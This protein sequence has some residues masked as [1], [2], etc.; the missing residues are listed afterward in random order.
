[1]FIDFSTFGTTYIFFVIKIQIIHTSVGGKLPHSNNGNQD[2]I[3][4]LPIICL[5]YF[6]IHLH[7][8]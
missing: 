1:M 6:C 5:H 2:T 4:I 8:N 7:L 3:Y